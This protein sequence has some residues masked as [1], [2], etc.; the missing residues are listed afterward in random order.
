MRPIINPND[1]QINSTPVTQMNIEWYGLNYSRVYTCRC[2]IIKKDL[3]K[4]FSA[5]FR[6]LIQ[7]DTD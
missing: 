3:Y 5:D 1:P 7:I 4:H 6:Q 2:N